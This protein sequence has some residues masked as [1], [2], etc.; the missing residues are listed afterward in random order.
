[1]ILYFTQRWILGPI[2]PA[3]MTEFAADRTTLGVVGSASLWGYMF[4]PIIAGLISDRYGRKYAV[5][6]GIFGFS[7][8]TMVCGLVTGS[9]QLMVARFFTGMI[10]AFYFIPLLAF[11]LE[12]FPERP[13]FFLTLMVSGSSLGW[14][15][16]PALSGW[17]LDLTGSWRWSFLVTGLIGLLVAV[18][19]AVFWPPTD[20]HKQTGQGF[21]T[22]IFRRKTAFMLLLLSLVAGFQIAAEFGFTMWYPAYL[23]TEIHLNATSAGLI[24]GLFGVGQCTGRP[25]MGW[26]CDRLTYRSVGTTCGALMGMLLIII[27]RVS[28]PAASAVL[29]FLTGFA[30]AA[31]MGSLWTFT[32]LVFST[33][34]GLALGII[35][36]FGYALASLAPVLIGYL[37]DRHSVNIGLTYIC[38]PAAFAASLSFFAT[39]IIR[40][41]SKT[42]VNEPI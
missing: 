26:L 11:T 40:P 30:G 18:L 22:N 37:G 27:L 34:K 7:S 20:D 29:C 16:G 42:C 4:T 25:V 32:G 10:E 38:I 31:V 35:T 9:S 6:V 12:L 3:L 36:T 17:L 5:L 2:I 14:F 23:E 15:T 21:N 39:Y 8:L 13:G 1:M 28:A 24:A 19:Q 33:F 41:S